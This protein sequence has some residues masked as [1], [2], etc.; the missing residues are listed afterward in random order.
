[1]TEIGT[2]FAFFVSNFLVVLLG[3]ALSVTPAHA[4]SAST[5]SDLF[6]SHHPFAQV[7]AESSVI[8]VKEYPREA[9][10]YLTPAQA[11]D[12]KVVFRK[13]R[14]VFQTSGEPVQGREMTTTLSESGDLFVL[15]QRRIGVLHHSTPVQGAAIKFGGETW[16]NTTGEPYAFSYRSGHYPHG[17]FRLKLLLESI[18]DQPL[19]WNQISIVL[20]DRDHEKGAVVVPIPADFF[21]LN[22]NRDST[23]DDVLVRYLFWQ[24]PQKYRVGV[25]YREKRLD[26]VVRN[27]FYFA[28]HPQAVSRYLKENHLADSQAAEMFMSWI[29]ETLKEEP[30]RMYDLRKGMK[31]IE[32]VALRN[33][34]LWVTDFWQR[35]K[36]TTQ[37]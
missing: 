29:N 10:H 4:S 26:E 24:S 20:A 3:A 27:I 30:D 8:R 12:I 15:T 34:T 28:H 33:Q 18:A 11:D 9:S 31:Y 16:T 6:Q 22:T 35:L 17:P 25:P 37:L 14:L 5:C 23:G 19:N 1:M 32:P 21:I 7:L 13:G 2:A 36:A